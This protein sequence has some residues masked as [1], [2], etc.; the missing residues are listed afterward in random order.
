[1]ILYKKDIIK[2]EESEFRSI[3]ISDLHLGTKFAKSKELLE[4]FKYTKSENLYLV[5]DIIDGWAIKRK[6]HWAQSHSDVVQ[7]I[8]KK[9]RKD[10][11]VFYVSGNHDD[12]L[13]GFLPLRLGNSLEIRDCFD[14]ISL[15]GERFLVTHGDFFDSV[16]MTKKWLAML[17]NIGYD[18]LLNV[19]Q[20]LVWVC[21]KLKIQSQWSLSAYVKENVKSTVNFITDFED[22]LSTHA[23]KNKY[24]GVICG[25]IHKAEIRSIDGVVYVNCGDWVE[26]CT[27]VVETL[28]GEFKL[29]KWI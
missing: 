5:G 16:T 24:N 11:S 1:M 15:K 13:R 6:I 9:A 27:A 10:T 25:H 26:S 14:Y 19:N 3:F 8:L 21:H 23:K 29:I 17:G 7:K 28:N 12:F 4:F 2:D 20:Q 18:F 22:I